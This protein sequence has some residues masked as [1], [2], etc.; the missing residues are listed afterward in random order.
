[1]FKAGTRRPG[2]G[3]RPPGDLES[4]MGDPASF[5]LDCIVKD[6]F[7]SMTGHA[8]ICKDSHSNWDAAIL[9]SLGAS[10]LWFWSNG[11]PFQMAK[12]TST[13]L[14]DQHSLVQHLAVQEA[15]HA[16][17]I[18]LSDAS[19]EPDI[20][21]LAS[22]SELPVHL[23]HDSDGQLNVFD[24][25]AWLFLTM[26][27]PKPVEGTV[28]V[29]FWGMACHM[30]TMLGLFKSLTK[31]Y[32]GHEGTLPGYVPKQFVHI[33][34]FTAKDIAMHFYDCGMTVRMASTILWDFTKGYVEQCPTAEEPMWA[35]VLAP[36]EHKM[37]EQPAKRRRV[38]KKSNK[39]K[40]QAAVLKM[41]AE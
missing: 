39:A 33:G 17:A 8:C 27:Q 35:S 34:E 16:G 14:F 26:M 22:I 7:L 36:G 12:E 4:H 38:Y 10:H 32:G 30:F 28:T 2:P 11:R 15:T 25:T 1:M 23:H 40:K 29:W 41:L 21:H 13:I 24:V 3:Q 9:W 37:W 6:V 19:V 18:P 5:S 31:D 20:I